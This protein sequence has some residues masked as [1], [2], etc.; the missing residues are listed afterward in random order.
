MNPWVLDSNVHSILKYRNDSMLDT[1][2]H[3]EEVWFPGA[4]VSI[5]TFIFLLENKKLQ[6]QKLKLCLEG[7]IFEES[8]FHFMNSGTFIGYTHTLNNYKC[9]AY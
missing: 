2:N 7:T 3:S 9:S 1:W 5:K 6:Q 4:I 8:L